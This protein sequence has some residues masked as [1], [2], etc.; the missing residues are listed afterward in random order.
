MTGVTISSTYFSN[1]ASLE[2][3]PKHSKALKN[4]RIALVYGNNGSGKSTIAQG[5]HEYKNH[6]DSRNVVLELTKDES[7][8]DYIDE[9]NRRNI[10]IFDEEYISSRIKIKESGLDAIVLFGEQVDL[11]EKIEEVQR[12][13]GL[14]KTKVTQLENQYNQF[15]DGTNISSPDYWSNTI[16]SKLREADG[17]AEKGSKIKNQRRNLSVNEREIMRL[18]ELSVE[19][20]LKDLKEEFEQL[21]TQ[22]TST[23]VASKPL[24]SKVRLINIVGDI[25]KDAELLLQKTVERP[26]LTEREEQLLKLFGIERATNAKRFISDKTNVLCDKCFQPINEEYRVKALEEIECILN[27]EVKEFKA[28]LEKLLLSETHT[29]TYQDYHDL[30][31]YSK[32]LDCIGKYNGSIVAH[33]SMI[34]AK[35]ENPFDLMD[36][37][38]TIRIMEKCDTLN[39]ALTDLEVD[40]INYN[41]VISERST[42]EKDLLKLNDSIAHYNIKEMYSSF[43]KQEKEKKDIKEELDNYKKDVKDLGDKMRELDSQRRNFQVASTEINKSLKY[44]FF[45]DNRLSIELD[46]DHLYRIKVNGEFVSPN[47]VSCGERNALAL[48]YFFTEIAEE[49]DA[50]EIYSDEVLLIVDD[51]ISSFDLENR[52]GIMSLLRWKLG[53]ILES[54]ATSKVLIMTHDISVVFNLEK[55]LQEIS[56]QC[57]KVSN[58]AEYCL[59]QLKNKNLSEFRYNKHNEYTQLLQGVYQYAINS[60]GN[61][62]LDLSIGN[63]MRRVLEAFSTFTFKLGMAEVTLD[64]KVLELLPNEETRTYYKNL[65][66]RLVLDNESHFVDDVRSAP[67]VSFFSYL[68]S[69]EKQQ[70]AKD[71]LSFIYCL[72]KAHLLS[73]LPEAESD[74]ERWCSRY[75]NSDDPQ[76]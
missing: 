11:E 38:D 23:D 24:D 21:Y 41:H 4:N 73:H 42:V 40:R 12:L 70:T 65:M 59:F 9:Y 69:S 34:Q 62:N 52:V 18:A 3:F 33:N 54:C 10:Y 1:S 16:S 53:Q 55:A 27:D 6:I 49:M 66:Y 64:E 29:T 20:P 8:I 48:C 19:A 28:E 22:L 36:Y 25:A 30:Y 35:I 71:V 45:S 43:K 46:T 72:N 51:P 60:N 56:K 5:F 37:E 57:A 2:F 74:L 58:N 68:S 76:F 15:K 13:I 32:V 50:N 44:I 39:Q 75:Q 61:S 7:I 17:W 31:S 63:M 47:K 14:K 26:E 67:E